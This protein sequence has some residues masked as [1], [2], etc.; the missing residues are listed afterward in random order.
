MSSFYLEYYKAIV[1]WGFAAFIFNRVAFLKGFYRLPQVLVESKI[2]LSSLHV[3]VFFG[4]YLANI[5][6]LP[7][8]LTRFFFNEPSSFIE[9]QLLSL[10]SFF[11]FFGAF[12][13]IIDRTTLRN[14]WKTSSIYPK[15][16]QAMNA[17][18]GACAWVMVFP[19]STVVALLGDI[20]IYA[21]FKTENYDQAAV[22]YLK[23][24]MQSPL[25]L[26]G[27][28]I[29]ILLSCPIVE[30]ILFRG[31]LQTYLKRYFG[32]ELAILIAA[33]TFAFF[34]LVPSQ[35]AGN[36]PIFLSLFVVGCFLGF[37]Y[38]RQGSLLASISLH[39]TFNAISTFH[40]LWSSFS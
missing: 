27:V 15:S 24:A 16:C 11:L 8:L 19:I 29:S 2:K 20:L 23:S 31:V 10:A 17:F 33:F 1:I 32:R 18:I 34:H 7:Q 40:F 38:E 22:L 13:L 39:M 37:I 6:F 28:L 9:I 12:S 35:G 14:M 21:L 25:L 3:F 4:I 26:A 36:I 30:E 5:F